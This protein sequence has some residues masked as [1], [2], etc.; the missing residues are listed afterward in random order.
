MNSHTLR[1][2]GALWAAYHSRAGS[3][4]YAFVRHPARRGACR[5]LLAVLLLLQHKLYHLMVLIGIGLLSAC[6]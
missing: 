2:S 1:P 4:T 5:F 3:G 6:S